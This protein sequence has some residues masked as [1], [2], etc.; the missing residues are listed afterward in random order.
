MRF[1]SDERIEHGKGDRLFE[2]LRLDETH[3]LPLRPSIPVDITLGRLDGPMARE[4]LNVAQAASRAMN[5]T[6]GDGDEATPSGM[7]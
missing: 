2:I 1:E 5:V 4:Q 3:E 7:R 6:G